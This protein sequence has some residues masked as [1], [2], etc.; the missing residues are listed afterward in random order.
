MCI[1]AILLGPEYRKVFINKFQQSLP[2]F[3]VWKIRSTAQN[4]TCYGKDNVLFVN[5]IF[6][7]FHVWDDFE[8]NLQLS[9]CNC[10]YV[11]IQG[12]NPF[13]MLF[14]RE[15]LENQYTEN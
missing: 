9:R 7:Y 8:S 6:K 12:T 11:T 15:L 14:I 13:V 4:T 5:S 1:R 10:V 3:W 2:K